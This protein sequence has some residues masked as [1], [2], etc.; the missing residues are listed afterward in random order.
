MSTRVPL[1]ASGG[2]IKSPAPP[3][4]SHAIAGRE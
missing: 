3:G 4:V 2:Q 1:S